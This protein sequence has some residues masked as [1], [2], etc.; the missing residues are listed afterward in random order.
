MEAKDLRNMTV[1]ELKDRLIKEKANLLNLRL[2]RS[3]GG[4][5]NPNALK[6]QRKLIARINTI[7]KEKK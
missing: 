7:M 5:K 1:I 3:A 2:E 4:L 6:V